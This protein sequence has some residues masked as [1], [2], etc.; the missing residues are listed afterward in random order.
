MSRK[1]GSANS[2]DILSEDKLKDAAERIS[3]LRSRPDGK[4]RPAI[5]EAH[6]DGLKAE[7][8]EEVEGAEETINE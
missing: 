6:L 8:R 7:S 4:A 2:M 5:I 3:L 1:K